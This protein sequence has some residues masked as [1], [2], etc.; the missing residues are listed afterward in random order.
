MTAGNRTLYSLT[1][2]TCSATGDNMK[3]VPERY[4]AHVRKM[5]AN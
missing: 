5:Q 1:M 3:L 2:N 4:H